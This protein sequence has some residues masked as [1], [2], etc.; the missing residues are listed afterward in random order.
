MA[1]EKP[2]DIAIAGELNLDLILYGLPVEMATERDLLA[3]GFVSTLGSSSAIVA[4]NAAALGLRVRFQSL[5]GDDDFGCIAL[6][7]L[8]QMD[9]DVSGIVVDAKL[10]TGVTIL[11]PHEAIRHSLTYLGS[12]SRLTV[13]HLNIDALKEARHFHL[14]SLFLQEGLQRDLGHL[15]LE[16]KSAGLSVS[17]DTNDDPKNLWGEPLGEIL[18]L[19]DLFMP[20]EDELCRMA[21]GVSL[22]QAMSSF[23]IAVP[24]LVVKRGRKGCRVR[25]LGKIFDVPPTTVTTMVDSIGAGDSFDAGFLAAYLRGYDVEACARAG[26]VTGALCTQGTGGTESFRDRVQR[27]GFLTKHG[28]LQEPEV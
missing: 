28:F 6:E 16:L 22:E 3:S 19:I 18:S 7:R 15:L 17:L 4:H 11:L 23:A 2:F 10:T 9:V 20:N 12:I 24:T 5:I 13:G 21:G 27:E 14:S 26:N 8:R 25:H 1:A